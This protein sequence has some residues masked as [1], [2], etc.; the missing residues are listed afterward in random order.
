LKVKSS[1]KKTKKALANGSDDYDFFAS[2]DSRDLLQQIPCKLRRLNH[3]LS[4][5]QS[6]FLFLR[7]LRDLRGKKIKD[8]LN[9]SLLRLQAD[10]SSSAKYIFIF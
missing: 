1:Q 4:R 10:L 9:L 2:T 7:D 6:A 8:R 5:S 3:S